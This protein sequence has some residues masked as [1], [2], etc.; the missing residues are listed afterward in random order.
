MSRMKKNII[1]MVFLACL[2]FCGVQG[3]EAYSCTKDTATSFCGCHLKDFTNHTIMDI[4]L[5][6]VGEKYA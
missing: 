2:L 4:K 6:F 5:D 1:S 3:Q